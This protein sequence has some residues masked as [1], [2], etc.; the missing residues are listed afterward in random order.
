MGGQIDAALLTPVAPMQSAGE[1]KTVPEWTAQ[2]RR[3]GRSGNRTCLVG[4]A[5]G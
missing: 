3:L 5:K 4:R 1:G 2:A